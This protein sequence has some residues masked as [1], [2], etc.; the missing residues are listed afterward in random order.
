[1]SRKGTSGWPIVAVL[2]ITFGIG[3][4]YPNL[5][6]VVSHAKLEPTRP[7]DPGKFSPWERLKN[8]APAFDAGWKSGYCGERRAGAFDRVPR[9]S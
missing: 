4:K 6:H 3:D 9:R 2:D 1:M 7:S 5:K 8:L